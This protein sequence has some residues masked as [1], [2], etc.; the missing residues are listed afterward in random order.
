V[1]QLPGCGKVGYNFKRG[2]LGRGVVKSWRACADK[3]SQGQA[4]DRDR[5]QARAG[6]KGR[7]GLGRGV[8][9]S[10]PGPTRV[11]ADTLRSLRSLRVRLNL[12]VGRCSMKGKYYD[13]HDCN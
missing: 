10:L 2:R 3:S 4:P 13:T 9:R 6:C 8:G 1:G 5:G 11:A 7:A 12:A